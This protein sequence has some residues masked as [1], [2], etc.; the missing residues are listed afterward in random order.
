MYAC[1]DDEF[2][3]FQNGGRRRPAIRAQKMDPLLRKCDFNHFLG[4][5]VRI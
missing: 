3:S 2:V 4:G 1:T 5:F